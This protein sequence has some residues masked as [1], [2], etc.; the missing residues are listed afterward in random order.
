MVTVLKTS[1]VCE[2]AAWAAYDIVYRKQAADGPQ[3][4]VRGRSLRCCMPF[5][6]RVKERE[7]PDPSIYL[8]TPLSPDKLGLT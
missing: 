3:T 4:M 8:P 7:L 5:T 2:G 6:S 1:Q